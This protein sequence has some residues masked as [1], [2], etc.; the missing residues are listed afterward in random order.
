MQLWA[1]T[2]NE[3]TLAQLADS[4]MQ[5]SNKFALFTALL[6]RNERRLKRK[7]SLPVMTLFIF[8]FSHSVIQF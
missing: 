2:P 6:H 1:K 5:T 8:F 7:K 3:A 4:R